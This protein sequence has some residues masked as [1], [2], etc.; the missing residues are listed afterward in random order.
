MTS[1]VDAR[2]TARRGAKVRLIAA[3][4]TLPLLALAAG[5]PAAARP[6]STL[7]DNFGLFRSVRMAPH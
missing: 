7:V 2:R 6:T 1:P 5:R 3:L 4:L